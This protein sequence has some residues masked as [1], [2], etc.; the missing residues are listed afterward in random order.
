MSDCMKETL[1]SPFGGW[2]EQ[3]VRKKDVAEK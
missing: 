2:L 3:E 1:T